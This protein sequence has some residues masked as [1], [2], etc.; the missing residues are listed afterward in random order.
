MSIESDAQQDLALGDE[1]A[2]YV[3]GGKKATKKGAKTTPASHPVDYIH[4]PGSTN[5]TDGLTDGDCSDPG[6]G[7]SDST[8]AST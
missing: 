8:D 1:D 6:D 7:S 3:V 2:E 5:P 4:L